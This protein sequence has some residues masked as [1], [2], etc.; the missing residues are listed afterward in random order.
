MSRSSVP[1]AGR[2]QR[3]GS[4]GA[5]ACWS[6]RSAPAAPAGPPTPLTLC[7][8]KADETACIAGTMGSR[9]DPIEDV[10]VILTKPDG[11]TETATTEAD[12][13]F[14]FRSPSRATT[15]S[16]STPTPCPRAP[17]CGRRP[18]RRCVGPD[19]ALKVNGVAL[20]KSLRRDADRPRRR[21]RRLAPAS[22]TSSS[23]R[24]VNGIRLGLLLALASVGLSPDLRHHRH[25]QL[26]ARRAGDAGRHG[27][28]LPRQRARAQP[29]ARR[30]PGGHH[31]RLQRLAPGPHP[32]ATAAPARAGPDP[33]DDRD[34]RPLAGAAVHLP[35][36]RRR[37]APSAS[38]STTPTVH[39]LRLDPDHQPVAG[40]DGDLDRGAGRWSATP[41]CAPASAGP[42][43][44]SPTTRRW[45]RPPASTPTR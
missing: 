28:L 21:L 3:R 18:R 40:G 15:S 38:S 35:V 2:R 22:A 10:D 17:S 34:D 29:V 9:A 16:A 27:R 14:S 20:G 24:S 31:L 12:G 11:T 41:C 6:R 43:A 45:P 19:G 23:S 25:L 32:V 8:P 42:P 44:R 4:P 26:R 37:R 1:S 5:A 7:L 30:R 13:K 33:A 39:E 36:L